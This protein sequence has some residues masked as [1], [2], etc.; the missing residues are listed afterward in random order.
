MAGMALGSHRIKCTANVIRAARLLRRHRG[1]AS[2]AASLPPGYTTKW[3]VTSGALNG[4]MNG[5]ACQVIGDHSRVFAPPLAPLNDEFMVLSAN[6]FLRIFRISWLNRP[7]SRRNTGSISLRFASNTM[8]SSS[9]GTPSG[10][11]S[12]NALSASR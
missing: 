1:R 11:L 3:D 2:P 5:I 12:R 4:G 8:R 6:T 9:F 10:R 7:K